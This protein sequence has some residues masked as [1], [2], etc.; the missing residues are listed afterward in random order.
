MSQTLVGLLITLLGFAAQWLQI[1]AD[2]EQLAQVAGAIATFVG[3]AWA[4][5]GRYRQGDIHWY[6]KKK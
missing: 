1:D 3:I 6:G 2:Q 5:Y 4:W